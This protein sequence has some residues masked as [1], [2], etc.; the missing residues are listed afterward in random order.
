MGFPPDPG[1]PER[2]L[3]ATEHHD[4]QSAHHGALT[5]PGLSNA[6]G[7][8]RGEK[9]IPNQYTQAQWNFSMFWGLAIQAYEATLVADD[10]PFDRFEGSVSKGIKGDP[11]ALT[12]S[13]RNGL[14][15]FTDTDPNL[16]AHC[17]NCQCRCDG[18]L[19]DRYRPGGGTEAPE[20]PGPADRHRRVH[21]HGRRG[22]AN[23][24]KG[25][26]NISVRRSSEDVGRDDTAPGNPP[27]PPFEN[28]LDD[29]KPFPLSYVGLANLAAQ[30]KLPDDVLRFVQLDPKT[31]QPVPVLA[32]RPS[33]ATSR[34][35]TCAT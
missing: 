13:Q 24:D 15:I 23:Y 19:R 3:G 12:A 1:S 9:L 7:R 26:Y 16:G 6:A 34:C 20:L 27:Q 18:R 2:Q 25:F 28:P 32:A 17:N 10:T 8:T 21:D 31:L 14:T 35:P 4:R 33:T 29:N 11:K 22:V 5:G 30:N